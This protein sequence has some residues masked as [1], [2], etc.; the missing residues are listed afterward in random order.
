MTTRARVTILTCS[1]TRAMAS[2]VSGRRAGELLAEAGHEIVG[3]GVV[4][5]D[6]DRIAEAV[7]ARCDAGDLDVLL[8]T[9][10]TGLAPRDVTI[11][12]VAPLLDKE[13][14]GFGEAFRRLSWEQVGARSV[15]SRAV[16]G[17][18]GTTLVVAL[19]GSPKAVEL[20]V[21]QV[22]LPI[23]GHAVDLLHGRTGHAQVRGC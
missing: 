4:T 17:S 9:G 12:A 14:P 15:L 19:P 3:H 2:D 7:R 10:G 23:L 6:A 18:R 16:A 8:L 13:L 11:E 20:A 21:A 5:D 22:L 1:D